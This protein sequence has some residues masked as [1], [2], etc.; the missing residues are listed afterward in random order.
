M[1]VLRALGLIVL[2]IV[3]VLG[4]ADAAGTIAPTLHLIDLNAA[5]AP[6]ALP[7]AYTIPE[8]CNAY[9]ISRSLLYKEWRAGRGPAWIQFGVARRIPHDAAIQYARKNKQVA[10]A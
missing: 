2:G 4:M 8:F 5:V 3:I 9:R 7:G 10:D 1:L 6:I